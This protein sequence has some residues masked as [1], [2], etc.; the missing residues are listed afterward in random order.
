M[1]QKV[2]HPTV[3]MPSP[4]AGP[5]PASTILRTSCGSLIT[6]YRATMPPIGKPGRS[7]C[8]NRCRGC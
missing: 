2:T 8:W 7:T 6:S 4:R 5:V 3:L 1:K